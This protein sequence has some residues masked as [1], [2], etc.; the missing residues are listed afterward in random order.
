MH[1]PESPRLKRRMGTAILSLAALLF[2]TPPIAEAKGGH[3]GSGHSSGHSS[4]GHSSG[5]SSGG[6]KSHSHSYSTPKSP[7]QAH[8]SNYSQTAP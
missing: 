5:S 6:T 4:V 7:S 1:R 8:R 2:L 3:R